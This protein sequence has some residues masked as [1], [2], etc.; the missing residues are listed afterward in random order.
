M[1]ERVRD[2]HTTPLGGGP[3]YQSILDSDSRAVPPVLREHCPPVLGNVTLAVSRYTDAEFFRKEIEKVWLKTWQMACREEDIPQVGDCHVYDNVGK[4]IIVARVAENEFRAYYN[5]CPHRGRKL[6]SAPAARSDIRC[7]FHGLCW[8]LD[9]TLKENPIGWDFLE[10]D[11]A[12]WRL[13]QAQLARWG[14]FLFVNFDR[15]AA[16]FKQTAGPLPRHFEHWPQQSR[17]KAVHVTKVVSA[18]WKVVS[19]AFMESH[20]S[21][22]TH[23][24]ILPFT[25]DANSQYDVLSDHVTR[26]ISAAAVPSPFVAKGLS[27]EQVFRA[28]M[29][30]SGRGQAVAG[31][32][33]PQGVQARTVMAEAM[34]KAL[35]AQDATDYSTRSD[36]EMLDSILYNLFPNLSVWAG[37]APNLVY[38]WRPNGLDHSSTIMDVMILRPVP[39]GAERPKAVPVHCLRPD[40][41]WSSATELGPL[42]GIF[43]QDMGNLPH[44]QAGLL[45]SETGTVRLGAYTE[46]RIAHHHHVMDRYFAR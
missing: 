6:L 41:P 28:M 25:A 35:G 45:A 37:V 43:D 39:I 34:R 1:S 29:D 32:S 17:Y 16:P 4:S 9:G 27:E 7:A 12:S 46:G 2:P 42:G 5:S 44:V 19:E 22:T 38:R 26:H 15:S 30:F 21:L 13:P 36:A 20:H 10:S 23:P 11:P 24:Q 14:G 31:Q 3:S 40:E 8:R 18:N 33:L